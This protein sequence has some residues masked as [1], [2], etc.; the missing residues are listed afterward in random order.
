MIRGGDE[1]GHSQLG[2]NNAYC[3]DNEI[4]WLNWN[5]SP[6]DQEFQDFCR[7]VVTVWRKHP[8]FQRR[9]FFQ[10]RP[11]RGTDVRDITWLTPSG[12]EMTDSDWH[13]ESARCLGI[14]LS[15]EMADE[16]DE[17]GVAIRD[18]TMLVLFNSSPTDVKFTIPLDPPSAE[19]RSVL[20]TAHP[21]AKP[22]RR[23]S[24]GQFLLAGRSLALFEM[25]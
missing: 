9:H 4:S 1:L 23:R 21:L 13:S 11:I 22:V 24:G 20:N 2:N 12:K 19:W 17:F 5:L 16:V 3:Q 25:R 10:G 18:H 7:K 14:V 15:G 6:R 8:V